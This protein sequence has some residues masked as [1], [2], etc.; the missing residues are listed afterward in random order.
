MSL[1]NDKETSKFRTALKKKLSDVD[2]G[3]IGAQD[4]LNYFL[5]NKNGEAAT[6][7]SKKG[8]GY[9]AAF[10]YPFLEECIHETNNMERVYL[11]ADI[12]FIHGNGLYDP[13]TELWDK[14][15]ELGWKNLSESDKETLKEKIRVATAMAVTIEVHY[16]RL[17]KLEIAFADA[18]YLSPLARRFR[19]NPTYSN[20]RFLKYFLKK[21][22]PDDYNLIP[23]P[24]EMKNVTA[25]SPR[26]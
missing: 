1:W 14:N 17:S 15:E 19:E 23:N 8:Q 7:F 3:T 5:F 16:Q 22:M 12:F 11:L 6:F 18:R 2:Q 4:K 21:Y 9:I 10:L 25:S 26:P 24:T 20:D 13:L